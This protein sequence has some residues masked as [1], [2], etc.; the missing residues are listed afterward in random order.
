MHKD[1]RV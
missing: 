1:Q